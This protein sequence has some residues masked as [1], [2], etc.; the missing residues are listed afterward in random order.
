M[1]PIAV[2]VPISRLPISART[3]QLL[4]G[5]RRRRAERETEAYSRDNHCKPPAGYWARDV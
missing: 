4:A 1:V 5:I 2:A 3:V